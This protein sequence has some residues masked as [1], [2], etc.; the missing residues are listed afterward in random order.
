L[1]GICPTANIQKVRRHAARIFND[2][3][4]GHRQA[5]AI[6][7]AADIAIKLDVVERVLRGLDFQRI[8]FRNVPQLPQIRMPE[9]GVVI[10]VD[11]CVQRKQ[12]PVGCR[13]KGIDFKE[14]SVRFEKGLI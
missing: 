4:S 2:V 11:L 1:F 14:R 9:E 3:H 12:P 10:E 13:D 6:H 5:G 8:F 7:H